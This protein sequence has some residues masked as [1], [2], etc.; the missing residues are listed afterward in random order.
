M[1]LPMKTISPPKESHCGHWL[2]S[3]EVVCLITSEILQ[4]NREAKRIGQ[5]PVVRDIEYLSTVLPGHKFQQI[6]IFGKKVLADT[7]TGQ[8]Y[9]ASGSCLSSDLMRLK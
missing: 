3:S 5:S 2:L 9:R 1:T 8:L 6:E 4:M 7:V